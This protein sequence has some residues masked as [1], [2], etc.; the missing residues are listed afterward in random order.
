[1]NVDGKVC[2]VSKENREPVLTGHAAEPELQGALSEPGLVPKPAGRK[3]AKCPHLQHRS[4]DSNSRN[5]KKLLHILNDI[6]LGQPA[7]ASS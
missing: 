3:Q 2:T 1:M 6:R 4:L 5:T 7:G